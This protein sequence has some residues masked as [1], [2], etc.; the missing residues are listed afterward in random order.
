MGVAA[1]APRGKRDCFCFPVKVFLIDHLRHINYHA[2]MGVVTSQQITKYYDRYRDTEI[3]F[4]KEVIKTLHL[5][6]RQV[7]VKCADSQWPCIINSTSFLAVKIIVGTKGGAY[8]RLSQDNCDAKVRFCFAQADAQPIT[9]FVSGKVTEITPYMNAQD[10]AVITITF[11]QRPPDDLIEIIGRVL[12]ANF[13]AVQRKEERI[14]LTEETRRKLGISHEETLITV[15]GVPRHCILKDLSFS[16]AKVI[17]LGLSQFL[18]NREATLC[19]DFDEPPE[20]VKLNGTVLRCEPVQ[21]RKDIVAVS[22]RF[23]DKSIPMSYKLHINNFLTSK[24]KKELQVFNA[25]SLS[26][27]M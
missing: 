26:T 6:P 5:D 21:G 9:F 20:T 2:C 24:R 16:G 12:E 15:Q 7:Y 8:A 19:I 10:L 11:S 3:T 4:S 14:A 18:I 25:S 1:G 17:L 23:A 27:G 13:N 22:L